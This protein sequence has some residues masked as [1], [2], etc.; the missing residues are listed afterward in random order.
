[1]LSLSLTALPDPLSTTT[2]T[3]PHTSY[4]TIGGVICMPTTPP[5]THG[6]IVCK[7][8]QGIGLNKDVFAWVR[9]RCPMV[10]ADVSC[11]QISGQSTTANQKWSYDPPF[12]TAI[13]PNTGQSVVFGRSVGGLR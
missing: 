3:A 8:P 11:S 4:V 7:V 12:I 13:V 1:M 9:V 5:V 6:Q 10:F 2:S